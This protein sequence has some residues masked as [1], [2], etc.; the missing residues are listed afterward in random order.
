MMEVIRSCICK[1][2]EVMTVLL[3]AE[4]AAATIS[5][6]GTTATLLEVAALLSFIIVSQ[7]MIKILYASSRYSSGSS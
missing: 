4:T 5:V 6:V 2:C 1:T 7:G 3:V